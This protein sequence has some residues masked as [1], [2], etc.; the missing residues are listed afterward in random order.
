MTNRIPLA[1]ALVLSVAALSGCAGD[2]HEVVGTYA[3]QRAPG[4]G[5]EALGDAAPTT[6]RLNPADSVQIKV[7]GEP[8][9]SFDRLMVDQSGNINIAFL[10]D[11]HAEGLTAG[12]LAKSLRTGLAK[13]LINPQVSVNL[14]D[15]G[16]QHVVVEGSVGHAGVFPI[17]PGTTLLG[18]I[19]LAG[20]PD[21]FARIRD[22]VVIRT[23]AQGRSIAAFDLHAIRAGTQIDPVLKGGDRVVVGVSGMSRFYQDLLGLIPLAVIFSRF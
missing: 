6:Y 15:Y 11:V 17:T 2:K 10:G 5:Q 16:S 23:D 12:E 9:L 22:V 7:Y 13:S 21:R 1:L 19:A 3:P 14:V 20:S 4:R 8:D 18:A